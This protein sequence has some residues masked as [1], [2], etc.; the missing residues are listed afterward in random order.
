MY[1]FKSLAVHKGLNYSAK[2]ASNWKA[3]TRKWTKWWNQG[4]SAKAAKKRSAPPS[5]NEGDEDYNYEDDGRKSGKS[6]QRNFDEYQKGG[7]KAPWKQLPSRLPW[8]EGGGKPAFMGAIKKP[9]QWKPG[10]VALREIRRYQKSTELLC[11][12][13]CVARLI[14][15]VAQGFRTNLHFQAT[16]L[17]ALQEAMEAWLVRL[18][19]GMNLCV[20]HGKCVTVMPKDLKLVHQIRSNNGVDMFLDSTW[21]AWGSE[22]LET[23]LNIGPYVVTNGESPALVSFI[24]YFCLTILLMSHVVHVY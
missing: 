7:G 9:H 13:L 23:E 15:E 21:V 17:M 19:E 12:K 6:S 3:T 20:I 11:C 22:S 24:I 5:D 10:T 8:K 2:H 1:P 16:A 4:N 18:F 14:R